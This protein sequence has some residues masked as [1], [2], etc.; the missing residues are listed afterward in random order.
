MIEHTCGIVLRTIKYND[1]SVIADIFTERQ[2]RVSYLVRLPRSKKSTLRNVFFQP[3]S[4]LEY[5]SDFRPRLNLQRLKDARMACMFRSL[6]YDPYKSG[7]ALFLAEFLSHALREEMENRPLFSYLTYSVQWLD[8]CDKPAANF[9]LVFLMHLSRFLGLYPNLDHYRPGDFFDLRAACFTDRPPLHSDVVR[10]EEAARL[11]TLMRMNYDTMHLFEMS[12]AERNR[13]VEIILTFYRLH[14]PGFP[15][16]K[17]LDVLR[18]L[19][20]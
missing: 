2:G 13:C 15:E 5:E 3:L 20:N 19:F 10:P 14:L 1:T 16:L 4:I 17:S 18:E 6:P 8:S 11:G 9:H 12:R 7:I